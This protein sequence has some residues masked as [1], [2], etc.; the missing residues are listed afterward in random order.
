VARIQRL[1]C[2]VKGIVLHAVGVGRAPAPAVPLS[3][4]MATGLKDAITDRILFLIH[5]WDN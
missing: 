3:H 1:H 2:L 5:H 4:L